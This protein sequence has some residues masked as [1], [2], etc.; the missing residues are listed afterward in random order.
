MLGLNTSQGRVVPN[1][2]LY[3]CQGVMLVMLEE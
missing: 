2:F 1:F 3:S